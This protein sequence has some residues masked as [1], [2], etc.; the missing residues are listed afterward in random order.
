M[1]QALGFGPATAGR[2]VGWDAQSGRAGLDDLLRRLSGPC[3]FGGRIASG[4]GRENRKMMT[5]HDQQAENLRVRHDNQRRGV[6]Q[7]AENN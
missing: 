3:D 4:F 6:S 1:A 5:A 2:P 7:K